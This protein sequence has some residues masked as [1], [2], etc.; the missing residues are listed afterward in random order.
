MVRSIPPTLRAGT[1]DLPDVPPLI[2]SLLASFLQPLLAWFTDQLYRALLTRCASHPLV[3]LAQLYDPA[4]VVAACQA[5]YHASG[6]KGT[7][8]TYS[9]EQLVRAEIV[10]AWAD[11]CSDPEL[12]WLLASNLLLR[13]FVGLPLLGPT[14]D[15]STLNR[16]HAWL[17]QHHPAAFFQDVLTFLDQLDPEAPSSTPQIVDT[18][19]MASP[20]APAASPH[21]IL[22]QLVLRLVHLW[23]AHA[24]S[25]AQAAIPPLDLGPL[26]HPPRWRTAADQQALLQ[27]AV[28]VACWVADG[29][30]PHLAALEPPLQAKASALVAGIRKVIADETTCDASGRVQELRAEQKGTYRLMSAVDLHSTFRKHEGSPAVFGS[31][32]VIAT[33]ATRIRACVALT[34]STP[35]SEAPAA[36]LRQQ[37]ARGA[38][39]PSVLLMDQ[40]GGHGKVRASVDALSAGQTVMVALIPQAGGAD[41]TRF[42]PADFRLSTDGSSCT[43]PNGVSST[44]C[45]AH[46]AG[47]GVSFRFLASQ[48]RGCPLWN[49]C[50]GTHS[51]PKSHRMVYITPYHL[52]LR[53]GARFNAT[54]VGKALLKSRWQ[55]EPAI[56]WLVRYH[57]CRQA[58][59]VGQ[60]AAEGQLLMACGLRNL[61]LWLS[62]LTRGQ[63]RMPTAEQ[64]QPQ[65]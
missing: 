22:R 36:V 32:A 43:C 9:I 2:L 8:P 51:N 18:F 33:T 57:G 23:F 59:R 64:L 31:N 20:A 42:T 45:Y 38:A 7:S 29:V 17:T 54:E 55:V 13:W 15:H 30:C 65:A 14:P 26:K 50:R 61:L 44:R 19:A 3:R 40:A 11:S 25:S 5:Y 56:A 24:P 52:Y 53:D 21:H 41:L 49:E 34:G 6:T 35:D 47:D 46:G 27:Q 28:S 60:A 39:L 10:R 48:C 12:E 16:F 62:R 4:P 58:R 63:A 1:L 37:Q